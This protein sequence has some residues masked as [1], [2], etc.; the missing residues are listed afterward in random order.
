MSEHRI[1]LHAE[2]AAPV[3]TVFAAFADHETFGK[4]WPGT[5]RRIRQGN[6]HPNGEGSVR[7]V[8]SGLVSLE[9]TTTIYQPDELL[10]YR[11]TRGT[12]LREHYG[13]LQFHST[14]DGTQV[15]YEIYFRCP[16]PVLGKLIAR[17]LEQSFHSH[18]G[19]WSQANC[20]AAA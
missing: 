12:P 19:P 15:D 18:I 6:T 16:I 17:Q 2:I 13:R 1:A 8:R 3:A 14:S 20:R 9:E 11:I 7:H 10:E 5:T 4:L